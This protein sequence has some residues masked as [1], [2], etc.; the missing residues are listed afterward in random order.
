MRWIA[1]QINHN[2]RPALAVV[3]LALCAAAVTLTWT[4]GDRGQAHAQQPPGMD[5]GPFLPTG[6][7]WWEHPNKDECEPKEPDGKK[8][9]QGECNPP[10]NRDTGET[11]DDESSPGA[12]DPPGDTGNP[13]ESDSK[14][15]EEPNEDE[16]SKPDETGEGGQEVGD[17]ENPDETRRKPWESG[18]EGDD[19]ES[20][21]GEDGD[22][23]DDPKGGESDGDANE[24]CGSSDA[25]AQGPR[26]L[27][28]QPIGGSVGE[29]PGFLNQPFVLRYRSVNSSQG[30]V[31]IGWDANFWDRIVIG[32]T[33]NPAAALAWYPGNGAA[34]YFFGPPGGPYTP[35]N[36]IADTF[37]LTENP[38]STTGRYIIVGKHGTKRYYDTSGRITKRE[39]RWG[40]TNVYT[41][42]PAGQLLT[43]SSSYGHAA[44]HTFAWHPT[45]R[46]KSVTDLSGRKSTF[47]Y[48]T[49][50][51][52]TDINFP[53]STLHPNG[54]T[55][56]YTYDSTS[57]RL[58]KII[59]PTGVTRVE[60]GYDAAGLVTSVKRGDGLHTMTLTR[61]AGVTEIVDFNGNL[62]K[63]TF[64][65]GLHYPTKVELITR[66]LRGDD[67]ASYVWEYSY[68]Q[69]RRLTKA[70]LP[71]G[72]TYKYA[73]D[74]NG[75]MT[76]RRIQ[77]QD[78]ATNQPTDAVQTWTYDANSL[79]LSVKDVKGD[80]TTFVR[81][82][83]GNM[84]EVRSRDA[85]DGVA[86]T[87]Y[88][89]NSV[90]QVT[91]RIS[92]RGHVKTYNRYTSG[93]Y[94][95]FVQS[96]VFSQ[97]PGTP[98]TVCGGGP[99]YTYT[100]N[101][102]G[103]PLTVTSPTGLTTTIQRDDMDRRVGV[104]TNG[105]VPVLIQRTFNQ[106]GIPLTHS[107]ENRDETGT[108]HPTKPFIVT[109]V[110]RDSRRRAVGITSDFDLTTTRTLALDRD[111]LGNVTKTTSPLGK[112]I[113]RPVDERGYLLQLKSGTAAP[114]IS[115][116]AFHQD[117]ALKRVTDP[118]GN[119]TTF[120]LDAYGRINKHT[121]ANGTTKHLTISKHGNVSQSEFKDSTSALLSKTTVTHDKRN[122][123]TDIT[124]QRFNH[125]QPA[126]DITY[127]F[128]YDAMSNLV[129]ALSPTGVKLKY[130][131]YSCG[132]IKSTENEATGQLI[133]YDYDSSDRL[134]SVSRTESEG[135]GGTLTYKVEYEYDTLGRVIKTKEIDANDGTNVLT[136]EFAYNSRNLLTVRT[137]PEGGKT[138]YKY[139]L[140][141]YLVEMDQQQRVSGQSPTSHKALYEWDTDGQLKSVTDAT[142]SK[143][144][145]EYDDQ[146]RTTKI[147]QP[148]L[149][150]KT[151]TY[152][153]AGNVKTVTDG[154]GTV[155]TNTYDA[156]NQ[157]TA[158]SITRGSGVIGTTTETFTYDALGRLTSATDDDSI[159]ELGYDSLG[160]VLTQ[161]QGANA[162]SLLT[163][164]RTYDDDGFGTSIAYPSGF[165]TVSRSADSARRL[166]KLTVGGATVLEQTYKHT[167]LLAV[168]NLIGGKNRGE[169]GYDGFARL[170][171]SRYQFIPTSGSPTV[172]FHAEY[173]YD[174]NH[175]RLYERR[176][177]AGNVGELYG[178]DDLDRVSSVLRG[179]ADPVAELQSPGSQ[180]YTTGMSYAFDGSGTR[181]SVIAQ[182][183]GGGTPTTTT[184][185]SNNQ[186]ELTS[187][188]A[189][190][191]TYDNNGNLVLERDVQFPLRLSEPVGGGEEQYGQYRRCQLLVR[192]IGSQGS[193]ASRRRVDLLRLRRPEHDRTADGRRNDEPPLHLR[194]RCGRDRCG[195]GA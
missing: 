162:A 192:R 96:V 91:K 135:G 134:V 191:R 194:R 21:G 168:Q 103:Y 77:T 64:Q 143:T 181:T 170:S 54:K 193:E 27:N 13:N 17:D 115:K 31:G 70:I 51:R 182:P 130:E 122:R 172:H 128:K 188:G 47:S 145:Y 65:A 133:E 88:E 52:L 83:L 32:P 126:E 75:N 97:D 5:A 167:N 58:K 40:N 39:D 147:T 106:Q 157:L 92:P 16:E 136:T 112:T 117:G 185:T 107:I 164:T 84:T 186:H 124:F 87:K 166:H 71:S 150:T 3:L 9:N 82:S 72:K 176:V 68:D 144:S 165:L 60:F 152:D 73:Y 74:A 175:R 23:P 89:Y 61:N 46:L 10:Q 15:P 4:N 98:G 53:A 119:N 86:V 169:F 48:D 35:E 116:F 159:V 57:H 139:N 129:E 1:N 161:K 160:N 69:Y 25:D 30:L 11:S 120:D 189:Q 94:K 179:V 59:D 66:G 137:E 50:G 67:P 26:P 118:L 183:F 90:G 8:G 141:G 99:T 18:S 146:G 142:G 158:R 36:A 55:F 180:T 127:D 76:E 34:H 81:D 149:T 132:K 7:F 20:G 19:G 195:L 151:F 38:A 62:R 85:G 49:Q 104:S 190:I 138:V 12:D 102:R 6:H 148:D 110:V 114:S 56:Q 111:G 14:G 93:P 95:H 22:G 187:I 177:H 109:S 163:V 24:H 78:H 140:A 125:G 43:I 184:Y 33:L 178:Y 153:L 154:M 131:Y 28:G 44:M 105:A 173:G 121:F 41:R 29:N 42:N 45:G 100:H 37:A 101:Q 123:P 63:K 156:L 155:V 79:P 2:R 80:T 108:V 171:E 174:K 113:E